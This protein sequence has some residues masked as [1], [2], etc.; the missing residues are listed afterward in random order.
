MMRETESIIHRELEFLPL[1]TSANIVEGNALRLNWEKIVSKSELNY[2]MG[3]PPFVGYK[4]R[5]SAQRADL[6]M[7]FGDIKNIDYVAGWYYKAAKFV[8]KTSIQV[9]CVSTNSITQGE[10]VFSVWKTLIDNYGIDIDFAYRTF[11]WDSEAT[12]KA[13]IHCVII[14]F[15]Y[16]GIRKQKIIFDQEVS[17]KVRHINPYLVDADN[18]FIKRRLKPLSK[19]E[20]MLTGSEPRDGGFLL[21]GVDER[22]K[23]LQKYP[24]L[25]P[26]LPRFITGDDFINGDYRY[27]LWLKDAAP[28]LLYKYPFIVERLKKCR[29]FRRNSKQQQAYKMADYPFLFVS[30]RQPA[31][32]YLLIPQASSENRRYIPIG[33]LNPD[34]IVSNTCFTVANASPYTFGVLISNVHMAW[35]RAVCGRLE[36]RYRYSNT[37]VYNNFPWPNPTHQQ[38]SKI[39]QTA[40]EI[41]NVRSLYPDSTLAALYYD[42]TMPAKLKEA[43]RAN[44]LAVMEAY[45]FSGTT[46]NE[47]EI[48][49][50]LMEMYRKIT[51]AKE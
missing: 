34:I 13:H 35:M 18:V 7:M 32:K 24:E 41:L 16:R 6:S 4:K 11:Q 42:N 8:E 33:Y 3:N 51:E 49:S 44:D 9:A 46:T 17:K 31:T 5:E 40:Q 38:K 29:E 39:Q 45:S 30:E 48:V 15:S 27:C 10:Q 28:A 14:A 20:E 50:K 37:I 1:T 36:M 2:I 12:K 21:L 25:E 22:E 19:C 23:I 26:Y 43:H 47:S